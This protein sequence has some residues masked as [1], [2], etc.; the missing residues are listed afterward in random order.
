MRWS[1]L[2]ILLVAIAA[3][4][5]FIAKR[6]NNYYP[7]TT[8][9]PPPVCVPNGGVCDIYCSNCCP[10][11]SCAL[12][13]PPGVGLPYP[14]GCAYPRGRRATPVVLATVPDPSTAVP[15]CVPVYSVFVPSP[16][17]K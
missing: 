15:T 3:I 17:D 14:P 7:T 1:F 4:D 12:A 13:L 10:G 11:F 6:G 16:A 5:A 2:V 9:P 8:T